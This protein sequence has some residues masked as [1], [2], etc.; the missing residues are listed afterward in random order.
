MASVNTLARFAAGLM[1]DVK[2]HREGRLTTHDARAR[3]GL[4]REALRAIHLE[5]EGQKFIAG[6]AQPVDNTT[7]P[8]RTNLPARQGRS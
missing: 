3:A 1:G 6:S 7:T 4:A 8:A 5:L 2:A